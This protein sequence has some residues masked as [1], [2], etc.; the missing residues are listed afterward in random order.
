MTLGRFNADEFDD[1]LTIDNGTGK[2]RIYPGT[3]EGKNFGAAADPGA[4]DIWKTRTDLTVIQMGP[5]ENDSLL[6]KDS[7]GALVLNQA[8]PGGA[9]DWAAPLRF[10]P[11]D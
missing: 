10:G 2:L 9:V 3:A 4:G 5:G 6:S 11:R 1:L 7:T 8:T